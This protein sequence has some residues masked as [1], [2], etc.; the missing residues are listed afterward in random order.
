VEPLIALPWNGTTDRHHRGIGDRFAWN[1]QTQSPHDPVAS[2]LDAEV[3]G[4]LATP[5]QANGVELDEP[6]DQLLK[7]EIEIIES[8]E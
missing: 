6:V 1:T 2:Y 8:G 7:R 3:E 4:Y 5:V